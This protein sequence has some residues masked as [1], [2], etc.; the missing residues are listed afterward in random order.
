LYHP[1]AFPAASDPQALE[2]AND[3]SE[4]SPNDAF[5]KYSMAYVTGTAADG[6]N[7]L[8]TN[9]WKPSPAFSGAFR[10]TANWT[11]LLSAYVV[12]YP[13]LLV[14]LDGHERPLA[15]AWTRGAYQ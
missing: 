7:W 6:S 14:D 15:G 5:I 9:D 12:N 3:E 8:T 11:I 10:G 4:I 1:E 13:G 2:L